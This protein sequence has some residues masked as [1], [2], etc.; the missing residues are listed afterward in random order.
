MPLQ[1][2]QQ[3]SNL[4]VAIK[5]V[6]GHTKDGNSDLIESSAFQWTHH[7]GGKMAFSVVYT[8]SCS[9][10]DLTN[11]A[12]VQAHQATLDRGN[13]GLVNP[14]GSV[15]RCVDIAPGHVCANHQTKSLDYGIVIEGE[16]ELILDNIITKMRRGDIAVQRA[17][18]HQWRNA[19]QTDWAR[20]IF[21][22]QDCKANGTEDLGGADWLPTSGN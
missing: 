15:L 14:M 4:P 16:V 12:D 17:T 11:D 13:L 10:P 21:V 1:G 5:L 9:P 2:L 22:L 20:L 6:T 3:L 8:T 19:S 7:D 18:M